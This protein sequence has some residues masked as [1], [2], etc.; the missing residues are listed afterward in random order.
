MVFINSS[1]ELEYQLEILAANS[2]NGVTLTL[3][4]SNEYKLSE[5]KFSHFADKNVTITSSDQ[6]PVIISCGDFASADEPHP[7]RG[8]A[9]IN[10]TVTVTRISFKNCG[11]VLT[12]LPK[13]V[14]DFFNNSSP[15]CYC[16]SHTAALLFMNSTV[17]MDTVTVES[18]Y[19]FGI[20]GINLN[21]SLFQFLKI[22]YNMPN[23]K[24]SKILKGSGMLIHFIDTNKPHAQATVLLNNIL[25]ENNTDPVNRKKCIYDDNGGT[26][27]LH[28][29]IMNAVGLTILYAQKNYPAHVSINSGKFIRNFGVLTGALLIINCQHNEK[30][31]ISLQDSYFHKNTRLKFSQC[32]GVALQFYWYSVL[33]KHIKKTAFSLSVKNTI[34]DGGSQVEKGHHKAGA[35][36]IVVD[37]PKVNAKFSFKKCTFLK[38]MS[39][40]TPGACLSLK[41]HKNNTIGSTINVTMDDLLVKDNGWTGHYSNPLP[42][43]RFENIHT[44]ILNG[45]SQFKNN[46]GSV[47]DAIE[48]DIF[49]YQNLTFENNTGRVGG[50]IKIEGN[51]LLYLMDRLNAS[52]YNNQAYEFGGA[53]YINSNS[54]RKC[55]IQPMMKNGRKLQFENNLAKLAGNSIFATP[56]SECEINKMYKKTAKLKQYFKILNRNRVRPVYEISTSPHKFKVEFMKDN[57]TIHPTRSKPLEKF[58]GENFELKISATDI[59]GKHVFSTVHISIEVLTNKYGPSKDYPWLKQIGGNQVLEG[60]Y[61]LPLYLSV[62]TRVKETVDALLIISLPKLHSKTYN[63][64]ILPCPVG[65]TLDHSLGRCGCSK[66]F[67]KVGTTKCYIQYRTIARPIADDLWVGVINKNTAISTSCPSTYCNYD[68]RYHLMRITDNHTL[69]TH[70]NREF[71]PFCLHSR[72]GPLCGKCNESKEHSVVFG[73]YRC[74]QCS[75]VWLLTL[76][77]YAFAGP[78]LIFL[79]YALKLTLTGGTLNGIIFYAQAANAGLLE[80]MT[81]SYYN[82]SQSTGIIDHC[83]FVVFSLLNLNLGFP[84]CFYNGMNQLWKTG[85]S[86]IFPIYLLMIVVFIIVISRYSTWL[87]NRTSRSSV[88]VLVT[89]V[90]LSFSKLLLALID[91]FTPAT[92]HTEDGSYRVWYWD[93]SVE[94]VGESHYPPVITATTI[95]AIFIVPY[96]TLLILGR[97]LIKHSRMANFYLRPIHEAIHAPFKPDKEYWFVA[98]VL[99]LFL[100]YVM[101]VVFRTQSNTVF[102]FAIASFLAI[103]LIGQLFFHPYQKNLLNLLDS[104]L[105]LN[106]TLVYVMMWNTV[107]SVMLTIRSVAVVFAVFTFIAV[108]I[109]HILQVWDFVT[110]ATEKLKKMKGFLHIS[111]PVRHK[112]ERARVQLQNADSYYNSCDQFREPLISD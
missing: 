93:G 45:T 69:L 72:T 106:I 18:S 54:Y 13:T 90:H 73:S 65:F 85:L 30:S 74:Q 9:F 86:L 16:S 6:L 20:I 94:Y 108:F 98:R 36:D 21:S 96:I 80:V 19:G 97:T 78:L 25:F 66:V 5:G 34:F 55:A 43:F 88:Q 26:K 100:I 101:F 64:R 92:I 79:L 31:T 22:F 91:V 77:I 112:N 51:G 17:K 29:P 47:I 10:S 60:K 1:Q 12:L 37:S 39:P 49:L 44:I 81:V 24:R 56:I 52:F 110:L 53:I 89:V 82:K 15:A 50:A 84:L 32:R 8:L 63:I 104:W 38:N 59:I 71:I 35:I 11:A 62:Q 4:C 48:S 68:L 99:L 33:N 95:V 109:Y 103:F 67:K 107:S 70:D 46:F 111:F 105:M 14:T 87:S 2:N 40:N 41:L 58:A 7:T 27:T 57:Q 83:S 28:C 42:L 3:N 76:I 61:S 23:I 75:N 102:N